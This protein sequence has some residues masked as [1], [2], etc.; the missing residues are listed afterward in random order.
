VPVIENVG[1]QEA[2]TGVIE[3]VLDRAAEVQQRV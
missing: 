1:M 2:V 3:L